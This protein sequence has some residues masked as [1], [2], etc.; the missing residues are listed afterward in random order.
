MVPPPDSHIVELPSEASAAGRAREAL[1][2]MLTALPSARRVDARLLVSELVTNAFRHGM[3]PI[4]LRLELHG[5]HLRVEVTDA[6][7]GRPRRRPDP[8]PD[9]G[10]G[11]MLVERAADR[12]GVADGS[13]RIWFEID[14]D[15]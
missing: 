15:H 9:G 5:S 7:G 13:M 8:G 1:A 12:W 2:G 6:G 10:W 14:R 3:P 11:L 4:S